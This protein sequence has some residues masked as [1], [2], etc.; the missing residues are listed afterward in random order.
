MKKRYKSLLCAVAEYTYYCEVKN[1]IREYPEGVYKV[2]ANGMGLWFPVLNRLTTVSDRVWQ[3]GPKGGVRIIKAPWSELWP[4]GYITT[5]EKYMKEFA[6]V[7][8]QAK[9]LS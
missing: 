5:N 1:R 6:W 7:K 4:M 8:L 2:V 3:Q 9:E